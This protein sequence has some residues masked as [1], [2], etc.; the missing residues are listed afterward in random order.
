MDL[1]LNE[2][3]KGYNRVEDGF[4]KMRYK[5][6]ESSKEYV[7]FMEDNFFILQVSFE[8]SLYRV[9]LFYPIMK[10]F[11]PTMRISREKFCPN[12]EIMGE[13]PLFIRDELT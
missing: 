4:P 13:K 12:M 8:N 10:L 11:Y 6:I 3:R 9:E 5:N 2:A 1:S 7:K